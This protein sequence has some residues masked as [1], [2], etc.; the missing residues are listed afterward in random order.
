MDDTEHLL[1][2]AP[3]KS[4]SLPRSREETNKL[5]LMLQGMKSRM[6]TGAA[7]ASV[8][9]PPQSPTSSDLSRSGN[10]SRSRG[11]KSIEQP[12]SAPS[13]PLPLERLNGENEREYL[14][15]TMIHEVPIMGTVMEKQ[16]IDGV[17]ELSFVHL[18]DGYGLVADEF[19]RVK[20]SRRKIRQLS[21]P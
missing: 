17:M 5:G 13:P 6:V 14:L 12:E 18:R 16:G 20:E 19:V 9:S 21:D 7:T 8:A 15:R 4:K 10:R 3:G 1:G 11:R 2:Q